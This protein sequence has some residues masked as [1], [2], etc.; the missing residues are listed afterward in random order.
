MFIVR[1]N[2][3]Y[4]RSVNG[5]KVVENAMAGVNWLR[6]SHRFQIT[7]AANTANY[8]ID[9]TL[10]ISHTA[11]A[12]GTATMRP[13]I[14]DAAVGDGALGVDWMQLAPY[15]AS[16]TYTSAV[17]DAGATVAWQKLTTT[18]T[19]LPWFSCCAT[20]GT[21]TAITYRT[22]DTPTPDAT[23]TAFTTLGTGGALTGSSRY[24][25]YMVQMTSNG[26]KAPAVQD[27]SII[28][29]R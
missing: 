29:K 26:V 7:T 4:A 11:M 15:T 17:F 3:L 28:Y 12:W 24:V 18:T 10:M 20:S 5:T 1:G 27:L 25:Q 22:G 6:K 21:T 8:Y 19:I 23:W 2:V 13:V 14:N 9:G 16:A